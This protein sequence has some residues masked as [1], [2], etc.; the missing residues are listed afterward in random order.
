MTWS[1]QLAVTTPVATRLRLFAAYPLHLVVIEDLPLDTA[2]PN[3]LWL[4]WTLVVLLQGSLTLLG[5]WY[6]SALFQHL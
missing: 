4:Y 1:T 2:L 6:G 3:C 5:I